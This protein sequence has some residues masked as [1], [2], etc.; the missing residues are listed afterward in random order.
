MK[1]FTIQS[2][3]ILLATLLIWSC[4]KDTDDATDVSTSDNIP[5]EVLNRF[6]ELGFDVSDIT[7]DGRDYILEKDIR[8]SPEALVEMQP[9][10]LHEGPNGEQYRT[11][12][13]VATNGSRVIKVKGNLNGI[14]SDALD[15][16]IANYNNNSTMTELSFQRVTNGSADITVRTRRGSPGGVA[17]FPRNGNPYGSV[18]IFTTTQQYGLDVL[19]HVITHELGHCIGLRHSDW[20]DRSYSCGSGGNEGQAGV[21]AIHIPGTTTSYSFRSVMN[22]C[23][24]TSSDGAFN[25]DDKTALGYLY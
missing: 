6:V 9:P 2:C 21:G 14:F 16:A 25:A 23:F 18:T 22:S 12:A 8:I 17:G 11:S 3:L 4:N 7:M 19:T 15:A 20:F 24:S 1:K 10:T 5:T 13:L